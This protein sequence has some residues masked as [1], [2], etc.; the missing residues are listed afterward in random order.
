[1]ILNQTNI[2]NAIIQAS[3][4]MATKATKYYNGLALG[5][6]NMCLFKEVVLLQKYIDILQCFE[7]VGSTETCEC[8]IV[9]EYISNEIL[10]QFLSN[11]TGSYFDGTLHT[12]T[13]NYVDGIY[14]ITEGTYNY[15]S[16]L[17]TN[18]SLFPSGPTDIL[19]D[20]ISIV[21][22]SLSP[23]PS[24][25]EEFVTS[26]NAQNTAD[27]FVTLV[28]EANLL[29]SGPQNTAGLGLQLVLQ[30]IPVIILLSQG[31]LNY[32]VTFDAS[33][34]FSYYN[35][36]TL[37]DVIFTNL[38]PCTPEVIKQTCLTNKQVTNIIKNINKIC[39][40]C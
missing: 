31:T 4:C 17:F 27:F 15:P 7:I 8:S 36:E 28:G 34:N 20:G 25:F 29:F 11:G 19:L 13:W 38:N 26:F 18:V 32:E 40:I 30:E 33:C 12:F 24:T 10:Y 6:D 3:C 2:N 14:Y 9:G 5:K 16:A 21:G 23:S 39:K 35:P 1:M 37:V 22:G